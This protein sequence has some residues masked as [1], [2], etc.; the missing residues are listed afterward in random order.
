MSHVA[1]LKI[2]LSDEI[3]ILM[4]CHST[5][6]HSHIHRNDL[7]DRMRFLTCEPDLSGLEGRREKDMNY[8]DE[9]EVFYNDPNKWLTENYNMR[10]FP[11]TVVMYDVLLPDIESA[12]QENGLE[13]CEEFYHALFSDGR[14][15]S[16]VFIFCQPQKDH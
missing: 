2:N 11:K 7:K 14:V 6:F 13:K 3:L 9:A 5:P 8:I 16:K 15:G 1:D 4:P 12:L 10:S